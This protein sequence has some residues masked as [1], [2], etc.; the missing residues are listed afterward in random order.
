M[1]L[2]ENK[3]RLTNLRFA[4]TICVGITPRNKNDKSN[5][6]DDEYDDAQT[7]Y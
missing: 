6:N 1:C 5:Y 3:E 7:C 4:F 2:I